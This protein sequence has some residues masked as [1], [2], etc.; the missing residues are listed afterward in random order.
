MPINR[1]GKEQHMKQSM[2]RILSNEQIAQSI[3]RMRLG[4]DVSP[5][6][7]PGQ[8]VNIRIDGLYLR[9]P[10]SVCDVR[11]D[12]M[13]L[14]YK[15]VGRG[16]AK[17]SEMEAGDELDILCGLGNGFNTSRSGKN[18]LLIGGG[19]GTPPLYLLCRRLIEEGKTPNVVIGFNSSRDV[20][21]ES[22]FRSLGVNLT[23]TTADGSAGIRGF[24]TDALPESYTYFYACGPDPMLKAV[25]RS[26]VTDGELSFEERMGCGFGACVGCTCKTKYGAKRICK[27]GPVLTKDE[28][29]FDE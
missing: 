7:A 20:I 28:V 26:T 21:L 11:E 19:V 23:V 9:R 18:P 25:Y 24:V 12:E 4:G 8:F 6:A 5:I 1:T 29:I 17:M 2:Y 27:D 22:D 15:T 10:I 3:Y 13:T 14:V 16:T